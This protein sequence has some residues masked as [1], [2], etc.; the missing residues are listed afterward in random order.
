MKYDHLDLYLTHTSHMNF[1]VFVICFLTF[2]MH[3]QELSSS[4]SDEETI[5]LLR[6]VYTKSLGLSTY[7]VPTE[8]TW[9]KQYTIKF[10]S[11]KV[12]QWIRP[13]R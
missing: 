4:S 13:L 3:Q 5:A 6:D 8:N 12:S 10:L 9:S 7:S 1:A 11:N 2:E